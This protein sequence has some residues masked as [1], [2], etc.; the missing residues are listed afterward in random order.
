MRPRIWNFLQ[1]AKQDREW[2]E[3]MEAHLQSVTEDFLKQGLPP[4]EARAAALRQTGNLTAHAEE[5]YQTNTVRWLD[6]LW[7]DLR[8][9]VRFLG[10]NPAFTA[11]AILTLALGIGANTA[12]FS[13]INSI[14]LKPLPY[15]HAEE[16]VALSQVAPGAGGIVMDQKQ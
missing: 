2:R 4:E 5:I 14:L 15:P 11:V 9:A 1:R 16:L 6:I 10:K 13:V 8:Y 7:S 12:V 3:E